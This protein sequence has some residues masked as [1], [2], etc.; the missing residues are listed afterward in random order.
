MEDDRLRFAPNNQR[1]H[2]LE[3]F[4][5]PACSWVTKASEADLRCARWLLAKRLAGHSCKVQWD[6]AQEVIRDAA[7]A[8]EDERLALRDFFAELDGM[9]IA[10][11]MRAAGATPGRMAALFHELDLRQWQAVLWVNQ[12]SSRRPTP[13]MNYWDKFALGSL[14]FV[15]GELRRPEQLGPRGPS[16]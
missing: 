11:V 13:E 3:T 1:V 4:D 16:A 9:E 7:D 14:R 12:F 5:T 10:Q 15:D 6:R 2:P 8:E